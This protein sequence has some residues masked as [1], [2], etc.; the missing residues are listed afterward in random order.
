MARTRSR[1]PDK[2][3]AR[4]GVRAITAEILADRVQVAALPTM[5]AEPTVSLSAMVPLL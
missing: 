2:R 3:R 5:P 1:C 4:A